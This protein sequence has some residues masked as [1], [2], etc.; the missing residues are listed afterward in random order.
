MCESNSGAPGRAR[1]TPSN[2]CAGKAG[3]SA[4]LW[5]YRVLF[6]APG[7]RVSSAPGLPCALDVEGDPLAKLG[8]VRRR[9]DAMTY[10]CVY[11]RQSQEAGGPIQSCGRRVLALSLAPA[12][13]PKLRSTPETARV[14]LRQFCHTMSLLSA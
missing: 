7:P 1:S 11:L 2:H 5:F 3:C 9:E 4:H 12:I 10:I 6:V 14:Q 8:R 13:P